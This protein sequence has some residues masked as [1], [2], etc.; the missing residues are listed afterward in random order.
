ME[1]SFWIMRLANVLV[2]KRCVVSYGYSYLEVGVLLSDS[3]EEL[4]GN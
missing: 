1:W 4:F 3:R 2:P